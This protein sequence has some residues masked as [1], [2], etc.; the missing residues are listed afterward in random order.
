MIKPHFLFWIKKPPGLSGDFKYAFQFCQSAEGVVDGFFNER[1]RVAA[2][3]AFFLFDR[4][5]D[6]FGG[7]GGGIIQWQLEPG[8]ADEMVGKVGVGA[9]GESQVVFLGEIARDAVAR[10]NRGV[11]NFDAVDLAKIVFQIFFES[12]PATE[13]MGRDGQA[14][15][16]MDAAD[17]FFRGQMVGDRFFDI[18]T[19]NIPGF[20][21][22]LFGYYNEDRQVI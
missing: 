8:L 7:Q 3:R 19:Q 14:A 20:G 10:E 18:Q 9:G 11:E 15:L 4:G 17:R 1:S 6:L 16:F 13:G 21:F 22:Y 5:G 2:S 12:A